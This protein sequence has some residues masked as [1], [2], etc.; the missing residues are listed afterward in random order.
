MQYIGFGRRLVAWL[1]DA[2]ILGVVQSILGIFLGTGFAGIS[3]GN[4][5]T[6][7]TGTTMFANIL[8]LIV[9]VG[10]AVG[11]QGWTGQ[12]LGKRVMCIKVV[13]ENGKKP[14]YFT[15]F[16]RD[17]IGKIASGIILFIGFLM[18]LWDG[19]KQGLHDKIASTYV[20]KA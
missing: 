12:T 11:Y 14:S 5:V 2:L 15:F 19:K 7:T 10:Y 3:S 18:I 8:S 17:V 1:L 9:W 20:V 16:L 13:D 4:S 6:P